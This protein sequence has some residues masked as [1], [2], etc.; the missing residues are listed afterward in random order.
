MSEVS[1]SLVSQLVSGFIQL[2]PMVQFSIVI[3][4]ILISYFYIK[5]KFPG[6]FRTADTGDSATINEPKHPQGGI[7]GVQHV[8]RREHNS[9]DNANNNVTNIT[10]ARDTPAGPNT[11][12]ERFISA[13]LAN[14]PHA[15]SSNPNR[16]DGTP[17]EL[18]NIVASWEGTPSPTHFYVM[19]PEY[20]AILEESVKDAMINNLMEGAI[21]L[22]IVH[23]R[24]IATQLKVLAADV[25]EEVF[26]R[27]PG[28]D[29]SENVRIEFLHETQLRWFVHRSELWLKNPRGANPEGKRVIFSDQGEVETV[30]TLSRKTVQDIIVELELILG[31]DSSSVIDGYREELGRPLASLS[32]EEFLTYPN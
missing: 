15:A 19:V 3:F 25:Q 27:K 13:H 24:I 16:I 11:Q 22:Y 32:E 12:T 31:V 8:D 7:N 17:E 14:L 9:A 1:D 30:L 2:H 28:H 29:I 20:V 18:I 10:I 21:Y 4:G 6:N 23:K 26:K 5:N